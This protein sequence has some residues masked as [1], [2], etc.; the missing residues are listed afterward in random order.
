MKFY[1]SRSPVLEVYLEEDDANVSLLSKEAT[2]ICDVCVI[3]RLSF[4]KLRATFVSIVGK[5]ELSRISLKGR[6][7]SERYLIQSW[8]LNLLGR[9]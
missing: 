9:A 2:I 7:E 3:R 8:Y 4:F 6:M 5:I 1:K